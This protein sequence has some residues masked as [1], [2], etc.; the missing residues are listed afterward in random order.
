[1]V[2]P[3][4]R[5]WN[6]TEYG[7]GGTLTIGNGGILNV[8]AGAQFAVDGVVLGTPAALINLADYDAG[9]HAVAIIDFNTG[10]AEA[11]C[12]VTIN[13]VEYL[14]ADPAVP[15]NGV[16]TN[17][18]TAANSATS[19]VAAVN[20]DTRAAVPFTA[21]ISPAGHSVMLVWDSVG[22]AGNV[23]ITTDS[24]ARVTVEN[25]HGG[26]EPARRPILALRY[27]VTAQDVLNTAI[28]IPVPFTPRAVIENAKTTAG[29]LKAHTGLVTIA[30]SPARI[31]IDNTAG[32]THLAAT[33]VVDLVILG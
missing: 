28:C 1:M 12:K 4:S 24:A 22:T 32:A 16:W 15:A 13:G 9:Q 25:S 20:G 27:V 31:M 8:E 33:D 3:I 10:A 30:A 19:F 5:K 14:E 11:G 26:L 18:A 21:V 29:L 6:E 2:W 17:G 7:P 23:T